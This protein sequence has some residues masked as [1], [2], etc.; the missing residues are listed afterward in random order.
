ML[1]NYMIFQI[2]L[3]LQLT[4]H[5]TEI[6]NTDIARCTENENFYCPFSMTFK[7][8]KNSCLLAILNNAKEKVKKLCDF[9]FI[10]NDISSKIIQ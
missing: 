8:Y 2:I 9:R 4:M 3:Q 7:S 1:L 5:Y 6:L 10:H